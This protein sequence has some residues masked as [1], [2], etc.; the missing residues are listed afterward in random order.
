MSKIIDGSESDTISSDQVIF[1]VGDVTLN[2]QLT[3]L[4]QM[5]II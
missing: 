3:V 4:G 5:V 2:G 1:L